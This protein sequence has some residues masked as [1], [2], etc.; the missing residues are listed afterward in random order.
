MSQHVEPSSVMLVEPH[1]LPTL[2]FFCAAYPFS[3]IRLERHAHYVKQGWRNRTI[4]NTANGISMLSVP[5]ANKG[6]RVP[7]GEVIIDHSSAWARTHWRTIESAY[8]NS[9]FFEHYETDLRNLL[10]RRH[11]NLLEL[12]RDI[13]AVFLGWLGWTTIITETGNFEQNPAATDLRDVL[14]AKIPATQRAFYHPVPYY[15]V[16]GNTFAENLSLIDLIF[17]C[18][19][20]SGEILSKSMAAKKIN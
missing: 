9:P 5:L 7:M 10:T 1:Y 20:S 19:P 15:Q 11:S 4:I 18:G 17:C 6:N 16:F 14:R 8:K 13:L 3:E 12:N 2:E